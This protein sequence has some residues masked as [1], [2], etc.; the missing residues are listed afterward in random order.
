ML[1]RKRLTLMILVGLIVGTVGIAIAVNTLGVPIEKGR[2][3][4]L[5]A[6][7][8]TS[9]GDLISGWYWL[10]DPGYTHYGKWNFSGVPTLTLDG[11]IYIYFE[12]LVTNTYNGGSGYSTYVKVYNASAPSHFTIL[13]LQNLHSEFREPNNTE[14]WGYSSIGW[15]KVPTYLIPPTGIL[16]FGLMR[17]SPNTEHVAVNSDCV[18]IEWRVL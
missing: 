18:T 9:N 6:D 3:R 4:L 13:K 11:Y 10:R 5:K 8:F 14:G 15:I 2:V 17:Y 7:S 1:K 12:C 16:S